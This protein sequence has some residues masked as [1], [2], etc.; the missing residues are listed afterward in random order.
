MVTL[1][2]YYVFTFTRLYKIDLHPAL[3]SPA[4]ID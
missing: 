2:P 1:D 3:E 4:M